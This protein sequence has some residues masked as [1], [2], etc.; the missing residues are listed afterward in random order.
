MQKLSRKRI[1]RPISFL[2]VNILISFSV[3]GYK[4][5]LMIWSINILVRNWGMRPNNIKC[6][7]IKFSFSYLMSLAKS[8]AAEFK[9]M[10]R[11]VELFT[12]DLM[13]SLLKLVASKAA[14]ELRCWAERILQI[15]WEAVRAFAPGKSKQSGAP[16]AKLRVKLW[17]ACAAN[18]AWCGLHRTPGCV[19]SKH[20]G[21]IK[22]EKLL[23]ARGAR[24]ILIPHLLLLIFLWSSCCHT[25]FLQSDVELAAAFAY[26]R[27]LLLGPPKKSEKCKMLGGCKFVTHSF[28]LTRT[29]SCSAGEYVS[30][31]AS[32][33]WGFGAGSAKQKNKQK[34]L[35]HF[36]LR[37]ICII[38]FNE[39]RIPPL[40]VGNH[41]VKLKGRSQDKW[42]YKINNSP[43]TLSAIFL[44]NF[45]QSLLERR[46]N[47]IY[48]QM[49]MLP[50]PQK[51]IN[52]CGECGNS[53]NILQ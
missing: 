10:Q 42:N 30:V 35:T 21:R 52:T 14:L 18:D 13:L 36:S 50:S 29:K 2:Q 44:S 33:A 51:K 9:I 46:R 22:R 26:T 47:H 49:K 40:T 16:E 43:S 19:V 6:N 25:H 24:E 8:S 17:T 48:V 27:L 23:R 38:I 37:V 1:V 20:Q 11:Y 4:Q 41:K 32:V 3:I 5:C 12:R 28:D 7:F 39:G 34:R 53:R 45:L 31:H 15:T